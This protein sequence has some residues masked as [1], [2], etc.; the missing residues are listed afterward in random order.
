M[1]SK[2][3]PSSVIV[4]V[5]GLPRSGTSMM[6]AMLQT[7]GL[8]LLADQTRPA[9]ED[10]PRGYFEDGRVINLAR[11]ASWLPE[12]RG[13]AVKIVCNLLEYLKPGLE[14]RVVFMERDVAEVV[15]SQRAMLDHRHLA[16][17]GQTENELARLL[18]I[19]VDQAERM[20][21]ERA[22]PTLQVSHRQ[23]LQSPGL[24]AARVNAFLGGYLN[25]SAMVS[26]VEPKLYR[27]RATSLG[28]G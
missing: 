1:K 22:I 17:A 4:V 8:P 25:E 2:I 24:I 19:M 9:D 20:L 5:S 16:G 13:R 7:G 28:P 11:D 6:M 26:V 23:C 21:T 15:R 10:N 3:V 14:Y 18:T 12:A 27:Q